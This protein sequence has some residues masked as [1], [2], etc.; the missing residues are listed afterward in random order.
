MML[1]GKTTVI[2]GCNRGI[3]LSTLKNFAKNGSDIFACC[4]KI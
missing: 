4:R 3:G 1:K 2:T